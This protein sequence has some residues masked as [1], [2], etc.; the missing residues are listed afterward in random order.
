MKR[1]CIFIM[2][3]L[4]L[5]A[6][7]FSQGYLLFHLGIT[8]EDSARYAVIDQNQ[9]NNI[10][11]KGTPHKTYFDSAYSV[12]YAIMTDTAGP[13]PP[14]NF[15]SFKVK[16]E[17]IAG[18]WGT[19]RLE[20]WHK[21]R[22]DSTH[23]GGFLDLSY[24]T[25]GIFHNIIFDTIEPLMGSISTYNF[26]S[27]NDTITGNIPSF[28][29]NSN[30][31]LYST[32]FWVWQIG[33]DGKEPFHDS[34]TIRFNF[35]SDGVAIPEEGWMIDNIYLELDEC[36]GGI[37]DF[38]LPKRVS[39]YPSPV[40]KEASFALVNFPPGKYLLDL[41]DAMGRTVIHELPITQP[42]Y[43]FINPGLS[44]GVYFYRISDTDGKSVSGKMV[45][46][47]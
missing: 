11:Q 27:A 37:A 46:L 21:Y 43:N 15:S 38:K 1:F 8:F 41:V 39:I 10:W 47:R 13:Y 36:T 14:D 45:I 42:V 2:L 16:M 22:M 23:A 12:P 34:L 3:F 28:T 5:K 33:V 20:F 4:F 19:G 18:C 26:Y 25:S 9:V 35:K 40:G 7:S 32:V 29:G 24:D 31:W 6:F 44:D 17:Y 30:G